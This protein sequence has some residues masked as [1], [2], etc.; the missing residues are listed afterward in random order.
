MG[1]QSV[2]KGKWQEAVHIYLRY[3][4]YF[5]NIISKPRNDPWVGIITHP[6]SSLP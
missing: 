4:R 3:T 2:G 6:N 1:K 5:T